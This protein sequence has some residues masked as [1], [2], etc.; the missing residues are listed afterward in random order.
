MPTP[1]KDPT[2]ARLRQASKGL[3]YISE[4]DSPVK[5]FLWSREDA[6]ADAVT[7]ALVLAH[8]KHPKGAAVEE[9]DLDAFLGPAA[10][11][12][13]WHTD[14]EKQTAARFRQ[15]MDTLRQELTDLHVYKVGAEPKKD[16]YVIGRTKGADFAGVTTKVVET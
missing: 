6:K 11:P 16:V 5:A 9:T 8:G 15:L 7:P 3:A 1:A 14:E 4:S 12:Q 10:L 2:L 13:D